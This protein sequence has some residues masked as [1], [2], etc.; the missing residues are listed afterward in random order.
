MSYI[1]RFAFLLPSAIY[2][3]TQ[4]IC[5]SNWQ[6]LQLVRPFLLMLPFLYVTLVTKYL[7]AGNKENAFSVNI[8]VRNFL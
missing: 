8:F 6:M 7:L 2:F 5:A 4:M 1:H 3:P